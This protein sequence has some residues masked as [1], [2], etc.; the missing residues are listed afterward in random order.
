MVMAACSHSVAKMT[1]VSSSLK[2]T[3][4]S[5]SSCMHRPPVSVLTWDL[6]DYCAIVSTLQNPPLWTASSR[7]VANE[8]RLPVHYLHNVHAKSSAGTL[9]DKPQNYNNFVL[10][11]FAATQR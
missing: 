3:L 5:S 1:A 4:A 8:G 10:P 6:T 11:N 7:C 2:T 9:C